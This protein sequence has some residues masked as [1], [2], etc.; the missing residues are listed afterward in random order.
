LPHVRPIA[1]IP[2]TDEIIAKMKPN[3]GNT[4]CKKIEPIPRNDPIR[5]E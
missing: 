3:G 5:I 4:K 1:Q 2:T